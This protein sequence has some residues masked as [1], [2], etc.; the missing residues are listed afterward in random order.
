MKKNKA[1]A[2]AVSKAEETMKADALAE[3]QKKFAE[4]KAK[5]EHDCSLEV[6]EVLA[7]HSCAMAVFG[8]VVGN[9]ANMSIR[10]VYEEKENA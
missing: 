5:K 4:E 8:T 3:A 6:N 9:K 2:D 7:K 1:Q 10:I